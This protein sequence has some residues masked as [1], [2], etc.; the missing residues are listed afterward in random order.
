MNL[1]LKWHLLSGGKGPVSLK[2]LVTLFNW[3]QSFTLLITGFQG[4]EKNAEMQPAK[5]PGLER[6]E[7]YKCCSKRKGH[8][9]HH[10]GH[11]TND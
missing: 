5:G 8:G 1:L 7:E 9:Y 4:G 3:S 2:G 11:C 10:K 6:R